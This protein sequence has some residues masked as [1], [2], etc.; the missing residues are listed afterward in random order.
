MSS[1]RLSETVA[2]TLG[3]PPESATTGDRNVFPL[4]E[5]QVSTSHFSLLLKDALDHH[6]E[7]Q[8]TQ[9]HRIETINTPTRSGALESRQNARKRASPVLLSLKSSSKRRKNAKDEDENE[10]YEFEVWVEPQPVV[11]QP[12]T[13]ADR[14]S[15]CAGCGCLRSSRHLRS[16]CMDCKEFLICNSCLYDMQVLGD[17]QKT[18]DLGV[19]GAPK[20]RPSRANR[21]QIRRVGHSM[22]I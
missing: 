7:L 16:S 8:K 22:D 17:H 13:E 21:G 6:K 5:H 19:G 12:E 18:H 15:N 1:R 3:T 11:D 2:F 20:G 9:S 4:N 14:T 10:D